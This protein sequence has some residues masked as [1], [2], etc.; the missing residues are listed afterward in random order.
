MAGLQQK[1][2]AEIAENGPIAGDAYMQA[3]LADPDFGYYMGKDPFG[4]AGDF[5]T[6]PEISQVFGEILGGWAA[7]IAENFLSTAAPNQPIHLIEM[8][9][10]RGTLMSD[11]LR[12]WQRHPGHPA[13]CHQLHVHLIEISPARQQ[14]QQIKLAP[15]AHI[16]AKLSWHRDIAACR[17]EIERQSEGLCLF[18]ANELIDALPIQ[19][20]RHVDQGWQMRH[21]TEQAG[22]LQWCWG[23]GQAACPDLLSYRDAYPVSETAIYEIC[24]EMPEIIAGLAALLT[25]MPGIALLVDYGYDQSQA[26]DSLQ[27]LKAHQF[28]DP[29]VLPGQAD[30]TAHVDFAAIRRV[31]QASGI[32]SWPLITQGQFLQSLGINLRL[33]QLAQ[34]HPQKADR[35]L[36]AGQRLY[37]PDAMG[38]LF[39]IQALTTPKFPVFPPF[40]A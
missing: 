30:I 5:T 38:D 27:A 12:I 16:A 33:Q 23:D 13:L 15:Q 10:G 14:Q 6:A 25:Q 3:C 36:Q 39:K 8:G 32:Q 21:V 22:T 37:H 17:A 29:L 28:H 34:K 4:Q 9:P 18:I 2:L 31:A 7:Y 24:P 35:L 11:M 19:Q 20:W 26:G 1:L 40:S